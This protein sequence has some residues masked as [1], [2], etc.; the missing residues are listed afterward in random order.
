MMNAQ[1]LNKDIPDHYCYIDWL[2][3]CCFHHSLARFNPS[4]HYY[5]KFGIKMSLF[6]YALKVREHAHAPYSSFKVGASIRTSSGEIY[7]GCNV[8]NVAY[9]EGSCAEA[10]AIS[11]MIA[12]GESVIEEICIVADSQ[13]PVSPCGGCRQKIAE[14]SRPE[15]IVHLANLKG[16][17]RQ[18]TIGDLLPDAFSKS[19]LSRK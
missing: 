16:E 6:Q 1:I 2:Q 11:A 8:E 7:V 3:V 4:I 19:H 17:S 12:A 15:T 5:E 14:F 10:G 13:F 18:T 9:P